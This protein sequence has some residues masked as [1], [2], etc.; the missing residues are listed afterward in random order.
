VKCASTKILQKAGEIYAE[1][2]HTFNINIE[3]NFYDV[4]RY[5]APEILTQTKLI[6]NSETNIKA[7]NMSAM[8]MFTGR[9]GL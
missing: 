1:H 4:S 7:N 8:R 6:Y 3:H 9:S 2:K 5:N